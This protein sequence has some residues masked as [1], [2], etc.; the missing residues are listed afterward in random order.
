MAHLTTASYVKIAL[1]SAL[2]VL[3]CTIAIGFS[4]CSSFLWNSRDL[5]LF[6]LGS[7]EIEASEVKSIEISWASGSV[8]ITTH[9]GD[10][11]I[12]LTESTSGTTR[13]LPEMRWRLSGNTLVIDYGS[14]GFYSCS[15]YGDKHLEVS[16]PQSMAKGFSSL[17]IDGASGKYT[18]QGLTCDDLKVSLA[19]GSL[20]AT[21]MTIEDLTLAIA[22]GNVSVEGQIEN[23]I[24]VDVASGDA[25]IVCEKRCPKALVADIMSGKVSI[26][27]PENDGFS[28]T[29]DKLSGSF[30]SDFDLKQNGGTSVYKDGQ[31][32][33]RVS[34]ASGQFN[35][36]KNS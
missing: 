13:G 3:L 4:T 7:A 18:L 23:R 14:V 10:N 8:D 32:S 31:A 15:F 29:L 11:T 17:G 21:D 9:A 22:S 34:I 30:Y 24:E 16:I 19:S 12:K 35:L 2:A 27:I 36:R 6:Q 1:I 25:R 28:L 20:K 5:G 33:F 26:W